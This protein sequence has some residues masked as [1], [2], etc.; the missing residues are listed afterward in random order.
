MKHKHIKFGTDHYPSCLVHIMLLSFWESK[1]QGEEKVWKNVEIIFFLLI[2][3]AGGCETL[4]T[5]L[6]LSVFL[7]FLLCILVKE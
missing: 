7:G 2:V 6:Y 5:Y 4:L 3:S 1:Y